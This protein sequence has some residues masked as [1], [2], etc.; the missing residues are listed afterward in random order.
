[1]VSALFSS[2]FHVDS[3][4]ALPDGLIAQCSTQFVPSVRTPGYTGTVVAHRT[5]PSEIVPDRMER[6]REEKMWRR[7]QCTANPSQN[8]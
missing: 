1:M 3:T 6:G 4:A 8:I 7:M 5:Y 2:R